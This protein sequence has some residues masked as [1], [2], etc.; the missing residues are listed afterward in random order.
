L[1]IAKKVVAAT[2]TLPE[3]VLRHFAMV[4]GTSWEVRGNI[5]KIQ[6]RRSARVESAKVRL[7]SSFAQACVAASL[8]LLSM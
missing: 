1:A 8:A 3:I 4:I 2:S 7:R 5:D 6:F